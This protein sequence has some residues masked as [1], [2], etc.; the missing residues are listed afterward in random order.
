MSQ[1]DWWYVKG[2]E[3]FGPVTEKAIKSK[4]LSGELSSESFIWRLDMN[5][6]TRLNDVNVFAELLSSAVITPR[7]EASKEQA[8][9]TAMLQQAKPTNVTVGIPRPPAPEEISAS[10]AR[11]Q[12]AKPVNN[13]NAAPKPGAPKG[14]A[15]SANAPQ[16]KPP[17]KTDAAKLEAQRPRVTPEAAK[18]YIERRLKPQLHWYDAKSKRA[19]TWHYFLV[20]TQIVT[21]SAIPVVNIL[22]KSVVASSVI[23]G[24]AA[25]ATGI[26]QFTRH[27][28]H[29]ITY[30]ETS[31]SLEGLH[32]HYELGLPPFDGADRHDKLIAEADKILGQE[33]SKWTSMVSQ[34]TKLIATPNLTPSGGTDDG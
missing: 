12:Q 9:S 34:A 17:N 30:R 31:N 24:L 28:E 21:T 29:W 26:A 6:W 22:T 20:T 25:V 4:I 11:A 19:K 5:D 3:H 1:D 7:A 18:A 27:Q 16:I 8:T 23:A 2:S 10:T 13:T 32:L 15:A 33:G 14:Q